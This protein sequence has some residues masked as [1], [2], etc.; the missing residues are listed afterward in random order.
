MSD[1]MKPL[2]AAVADRSLTAAEAEQAFVLL[3]EGEA[4]MRRSAPC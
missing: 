1:H 3:F 2:I 4:P